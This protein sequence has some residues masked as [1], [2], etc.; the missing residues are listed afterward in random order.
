MPATGP[1]Y[2]V[3]RFPARPCGGFRARSSVGEHSPYKRGVAGSKPAAPTNP[4]TTTVVALRGLPCEAL[5]RSE[6]TRLR[7]SS[8]RPY[9]GGWYRRITPKAPKCSPLSPLLL[10][11]ASE[12]PPYRSSRASAHRRRKSG[13][14]S[15]E[16]MAWS[17]SAETCPKTSAPSSP[18]STSSRW[19]SRSPKK[20]T[21][22][23]SDLHGRGS[24]VRRLA[25]NPH[26]CPI[27]GGTAPGLVDSRG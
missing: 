19:R 18:G 10:P 17:V 25:V 4:Y 27:L 14:H 16:V 23:D 21:E 6:N 26:A 24:V 22:H 5:S 2:G 13:E 9:G 11:R 15:M 1:P 8:N 12:S 7:V 3:R 20:V